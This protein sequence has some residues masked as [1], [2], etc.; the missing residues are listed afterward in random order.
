[1]TWH[2]KPQKIAPNSTVCVLSSKIMIDRFFFFSPSKPPTL[3]D[4]LTNH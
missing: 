1:M 3:A 2:H 4:F